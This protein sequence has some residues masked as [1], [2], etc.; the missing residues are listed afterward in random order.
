M[1]GFW[2]S[3]RENY[4]FS[5]KE[6]RELFWT[7]LAFAFIL[8][9]YFKKFLQKPVILED[10]VFFF[11]VVLIFSLVALYIHV[12]MQKL[13]GIKLGYKVTYSYWLNGILICVFLSLLTFGM[14]PILSTLILPG[15]VTM[16]H[17]P[18]LRLGKFRYGTNTKDIARVSL[19]GPLSH[20]VLVMILGI[21]YFAS[22]KSE[23]IFTFILI[24]LLLA[25][26]SMLPLP[27]IDIPTR[28]N[29]AA[30][31]LGV[32]FFSRTIYVLCLVTI[33]AYAILIW[34]ATIFSFITALAI[35]IVVS[36]IYA[37]TVEQQSGS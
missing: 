29:S 12:A 13:V 9:A 27:K 35:G 16:E 10:A 22:G 4:S 30:D 23:I 2:Y 19:A 17:L 36:I 3:V 34:I 8:T 15:A 6:L 21:L 25:I 32:F 5:G 18:K 33:I 28:M 11:V 14:V 31:G 7:S 37:M 20:V 26:Y 24:N 1:Y